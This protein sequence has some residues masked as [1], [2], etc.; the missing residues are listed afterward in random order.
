MKVTHVVTLVSDDG[1]YGGPVSVATGQLGEL[2]ARGHEVE[3]VSLW[4][5]RSAPPRSVDGVPLRARRARTLVPGQGFLG[6][7]HPG[8]LPLLW[9]RA[10][11]ADVLHLHAGRDLVSLAALVVAVVRRR[12]FLV[13]TH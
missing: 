6:L 8:L 13:Q 1:A 10:G 5:G 3:L 11:R 9:R 2:A 12:P 7:F 4:R